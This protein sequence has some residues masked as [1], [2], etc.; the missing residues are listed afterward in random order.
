MPKRW[1]VHEIED[2]MTHLMR[3]GIN[4]LAQHRVQRRDAGQ[5]DFL[6]HISLNFIEIFI[7]N[8]HARPRVPGV[9]NAIASGDPERQIDR[10]LKWAED[11]LQFLEYAMLPY[12][13]IERLM[14]R[15]FWWLVVDEDPLRLPVRSNRYTR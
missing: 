11:F 7:A 6:R 5:G 13:V 9:G 10:Q 4:K 12:K 15:I 3:N 1:Y 14:S 8:G 2:R